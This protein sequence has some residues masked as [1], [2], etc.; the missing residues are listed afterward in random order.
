MDD[1]GLATATPHRSGSGSTI[2]TKEKVTV[3]NSGKTDNSIYQEKTSIA[4]AS[5]IAISCDIDTA[6]HETSAADTSQVDEDS[7][8]HSTLAS[9]L[10]PD[11]NDDT[12]EHFATAY[13]VVEALEEEH[14]NLKFQLKITSAGNILL[15]P[16][17]TN[18][19]NLIK[20]ITE[21]RGKPI[22][23]LP[24]ETPSIQAIL[25]H[26]PVTLPLRPILRHPRVADAERCNNNL[27]GT[28]TRQVLITITG[29]LPPFLDLGN[30]GKF[31]T[32]PYTKEPIR[33]HNCQ[34]FGHHRANC[35]QQER[36]G[37]CSGYHA[38][39]ICLKKY[40]ERQATTAKCPNYK[41]EHHAWHRNCP[42]RQALIK[43]GK[44]KQEAWV[45]SHKPTPARYQKIIH[46]AQQTPICTGTNFP[47]LQAST[48]ITNRQA[49]SPQPTQNAQEAAKPTAKMS[50]SQAASRASIPSNIQ[51]I[52]TPEATQ[53]TALSQLPSTIQPIPT[54][55]ASQITAL[56]QPPSTIQP[57]PIPEA[58]QTI[59]PSQPQDS[60][61]PIQPIFSENH[62][63][64]TQTPESIHN[65]QPSIS[66]PQETLTLTKS[67]LKDILQNF[68]LA[69]AGLM[70]IPINKENIQ[71]C[72]NTINTTLDAS[73]KQSESCQKMKKKKKSMRVPRATP[74]STRVAGKKKTP[75]Q[76]A[77]HQTPS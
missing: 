54:P 42:Y 74:T 61:S 23:F 38:T 31:Y 64:Q 44:E 40:K 30:W 55:E 24:P 77:K 48:N 51:P 9:N 66:S 62:N 37:I 5:D 22:K 4:I 12:D 21:M 45:T 16:S 7:D 11:E 19:L 49:T 60:L 70:N 72:D 15:T 73:K 25:L 75:G 13:D 27:S 76:K 33:C 6:E 57:I 10:S 1:E 8:K 59:A 65:T 52:P 36:C 18:T 43:A 3:T 69:L 47:I 20:N 32:R 39:T 63:T 67:D 56:S 34:R 29:P 41:M 53:I 2:S 17:D 14:P 46:Q 71:T 35:Y 50:Y 58:P 68:A 28:P 26:Y